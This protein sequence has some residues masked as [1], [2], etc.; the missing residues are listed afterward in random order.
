MRNR[1]SV[2]LAAATSLLATAIVLVGGRVEAQVVVKTRAGEVS[3]PVNGTAVMQLP[4]GAEHIAVHWAGNPDAE[5]MVATSADGVHFGPDAD[6]GRDEVGEHRGNGETYGAVL[7]AG[8]AT[9]VRV[10]ANRPLGRV[11]VLAMADGERVTSYRAVPGRPAHGAVASHR[12]S[13]AS[14][15]APTSR[16]ASTPRATR[17]GRPSSIRCRS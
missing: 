12:S 3:R 16:C 10:S 13:P 1:R 15:G 5:V 9:A 8:G 14:T 2:V 17:S 6:V 7:P 11:T 4:F